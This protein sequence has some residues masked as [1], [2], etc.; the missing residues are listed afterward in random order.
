MITELR[1]AGATTALQAKAVLQQFLP[2][3]NR[4]F[5]VPAQCPEPAFRPMAPDLCLEQVLCFKH[6]RRVARDNTVKFQ[7]HTLQLLPGPE[8]R[9]YAG[10]VVVV[11]EGLDGRLSVQHEGRVIA[12]QEA[13]PNAGSLQNCKG[14]SPSVTLPSHVPEDLG[15]LQATAPET[16]NTM[17]DEAKD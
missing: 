5:G 8:R 2:R 4:R 7:R 6:R 16:L 3:F 14:P 13:P 17:I 9:S 10:A 12:T 1:L 11:M 15:E